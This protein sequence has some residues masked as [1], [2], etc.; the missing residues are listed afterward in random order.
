MNAAIE[1]LRYVRVQDDLHGMAVNDSGQVIMACNPNAIRNTMHFAINGIV[2]DHAYGRFNLDRDGALKGKIVVIADPSQMGVPA[3]FN[4]ADTWFR[5]GAT[6]DQHGALQR[7]LDVGC[8]TVVVPH[9]MD[10]PAGLHAVFYDG[11]IEGRD[12]AVAQTLALQ[13]VTQRQI[14]FRNW[15]NSNETD[16][17]AWAKDT[18]N[19]LYP[20]QAQYIHVGMHDTS[21]DGDLEMVGIA[22]RVQAFRQS[23]ETFTVNAMGVSEKHL[24]IIERAHKTGRGQL[25]TFMVGLSDEEF[26]RCGLF[27]DHL[28]GQLN[29]DMALAQQVAVEIGEKENTRRAVF[30]NIEQGLH[31]LAPHGEI[32]VADAKGEN[33]TKLAPAAVARRLMD[34]ELGITDQVWIHGQSANWQPMLQ[35]PLRDMFYQARGEVVPKGMPTLPGMPPPLP[36]EPTKDSLRVLSEAFDR[37]EDGQVL[38]ELFANAVQFTASE[39]QAT[40]LRATHQTLESLHAFG[41]SIA[42]VALMEGDQG[43]LAQVEAAMA[44][45]NA[46]AAPTRDVPALPM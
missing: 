35:S 38:A 12:A 39:C 40:G 43:V 14:G 33:M 17:L 41:T 46:L 29:L 23:G 20:G 24:D 27:Y 7:H 25:D 26:E 19:A 6:K 9:G 15:K 37:G 4:Q 32:Y 44:T 42:G 5:M 2:S 11:T 30:A 45:R 8:A 21:P 28:R 16:A 18:A 1:Q 3:G 10:V 22:A 13:N 31:A 34:N 36:V